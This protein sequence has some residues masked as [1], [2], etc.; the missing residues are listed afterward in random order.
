MILFSNLNIFEI[1][2]EK[3]NDVS[4]G[5]IG[6][7]ILTPLYKYTQP[8]IRYETNDHLLLSSRGDDKQGFQK[9]KKI[10]GRNE[11]ILWFKGNNNEKL[12]LHPLAL[13]DFFVPGLEKMQFI[14]TNKTSLLM[15]AV[16]NNNKEDV[17]ANIQ[18]KMSEILKINQLDDIVTFQVEVVDHIPN[19]PVT[20]KSRLVIPFTN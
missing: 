18:K 19:D 3:M 16:I 10:V 12:F 7:L 5:E 8:L 4:E 1:V 11:E 9:I 2:D 13:V 17:T 15:K 6:K 14:Q 20:G